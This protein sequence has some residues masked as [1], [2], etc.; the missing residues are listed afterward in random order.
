MK[1]INLLV[2]ILFLAGTSALAQN[3]KPEKAK[4]YKYELSISARGGYDIL[5]WY[6][7]NM[8]FIDY[9]GG[10]MGG[11]SVDYFWRSVGLG[12][13]VD[14]LRNKPKNTFPTVNLYNTDYNP[15]ELIS[16]FKLTEDPVT[17]VFYGLGPGFRY[18]GWNRKFSV[19]L[20][21]RA[22][23]ASIKGGYT[24]LSATIPAPILLNFHA[25]YKDNFVLTGKAQLRFNYFISERFGV[26]AG[27]YFMHH[28]GAK[29]DTAFS[30]SS[31][32]YQVT[33]EG[34]LYLTGK[35]FVAERNSVKNNISSLGVFGGVIFR[36]GAST[37]PDEICKNCNY[38]LTVIAR[39]KYTGEVLPDTD[40]AVFNL[41]GVVIKT[42]KTNSFGMVSFD[43]L[44]PATYSIEG[45]LHG[46][47][48]E[49]TVITKA[50]FEP[51]KNVQKEIVYADR[52]FIINGVAYTCNTINP[53]TGVTVILENNEKAIRKSTITDTQGRFVLHLP[54]TGIYSLYGKKAN[55]FSQIEEINALVYN[56]EKNLF[57]KLEL[58]AQEIECDK[59]IKL[60]NIHYD[61]D[62]AF[63]RTDAMPELNKLVQFMTDN[64][65]VNIELGSHTDSRASDEYNQ[66]L[67]QNRANAAV[68]YIVS[69]GI[70]R[71]RIIAI[72]YGESRLLNR[73]AD[74]VSCS[75]T[76]HQLNRRT[77]FK[78]ICP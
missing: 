1:R 44:T 66:L 70:E 25:G 11:V 36:F 33:P 6:R 47:S 45:K 15:I 10:I 19:Q 13:D 46:I 20:D 75:E 73:C 35:E 38:G 49:K 57:I 51:D 78:V 39:D 18:V 27:T 28:F 48:L 64:T 60:E 31:Q 21:I 5:Q 14:Y 59:N 29:S 7:N 50:E 32:Y 8:P 30:V 23:L 24:K 65:S 54:E 41:E 43:D 67:S 76:E 72:G 52:S 55:F 3:E 77:E 16:D 61:L 63:I 58:C 42:G 34:E 62:K 12:V 56:R 26:T 74:G 69:R 68:D 9:K 71:S 40:I 17:R 22:G 4:P 53:I 2:L 37:K